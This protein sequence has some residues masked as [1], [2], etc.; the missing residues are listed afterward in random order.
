MTQN[1]Y[2]PCASKTNHVSRVYNAVAI[3][4]VQFMVHILL[5]PTLNV[6]YFY[7]STLPKYV[8]GA[9][10][11]YFLSFL[12]FVFFRYVVLVFRQ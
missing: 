3:L 5:L 4:H 9:H 6:L 1:Y 2:S 7:I 10:C 11:G 12:D 8:R